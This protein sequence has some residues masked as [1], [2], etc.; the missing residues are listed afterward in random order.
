M[1]KYLAIIPAIF[2]VVS[3][4]G[5]KPAG[6]K[7]SSLVQEPAAVEEPE[8][9]DTEGTV[10]LEAFSPIF[11]TDEISKRELNYGLLP[12]KPQFHFD[13][14]GET[15]YVYDVIPLVEEDRY[16]YYVKRFT[17]DI[18][19][20]FQNWLNRSN[21][22][23]YIVKD[24]L[25]RE[26]VP[27]ELAYLPFTESGFNATAIS[28]AGASGMWQF[29]RGTGKSYDLNDNFWVDER[30]DFEKA[31]TAA[32]RHLRD[33]YEDLGDWHLALAAYNAGMGKIIRAIR[34]YESRDFYTLAKYSYLK[35]ETKDYVPKYLALRHIFCNYQEFGFE[36][37]VETPLI[38]DRLTV[39]R[40]VNL[41]VIAKLTGTS[42][43]ALKELNPELKTPVTPPVG[44]YTIRIPYGTAESAGTQIASMSQDELLM[45]KIYNAKRGEKLDSIAKKYSVSVNDIKSSNGLLHTKLYT[46]TPIFIPVKKYHDPALDREFAKVLKP[47]NPKVHVVRKGENLSTIARKYGLG[48]NEVVAMNKGIKPSKIR[49][50]QN[51]IVSVDYKRSDKRYVAQKT[52]YKKYNTA[53]AKKKRHVVKSG[54][55]LW[56]I[57]QKYGTTVNAIKRTNKLSG[58]Q[59]LPG[60]VLIITD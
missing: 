56:A 35:Q 2:F 12:S 34:M 24:I 4:A 57:A 9:L 1:K 46:D 49:P 28:R 19:N 42:Y 60:K 55:S 54:E 3:C 5:S 40:Q 43:S 26:G 38:F 45:Y 8:E 15:R 6:P 33:L 23:L 10:Q 53:A 41:Y 27:D 13:D 59:I 37:P 51:I 32:A 48:L 16:E 7:Y 44:S 31:T 50:G 36:T 47:Y 22:Y 52:T 39:D 11:L 14:I 17:Q 21:K 25:R 30:R 29:M 18:P 58:S 20:V